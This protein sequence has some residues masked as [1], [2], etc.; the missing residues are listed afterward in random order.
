MDY[1]DTDY[2]TEWFKAI[3]TKKATYK[4]VIEFLEDKITTK[5]G[6]LMKITTTNSKAFSLTELSNFC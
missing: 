2:F 6:V 1:Q 4:A 3:P 5:F